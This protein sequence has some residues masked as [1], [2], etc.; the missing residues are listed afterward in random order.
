MDF[1]IHTLG[2]G[3]FVEITKML[4]K[5]RDFWFAIFFLKIFKIHRLVW[6]FLWLFG[7][8]NLFHQCFVQVISNF[9]FYKHCFIKEDFCKTPRAACPSSPAPATLPVV[10]L[11]EQLVPLLQHQLLYLF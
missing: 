10:R 11:H 2:N 3:F 7:V 9:I 8:L 4:Q 1:Q 5:S 6:I